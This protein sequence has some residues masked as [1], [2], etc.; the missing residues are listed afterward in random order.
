ML[1]SLSLVHQ[2]NEIRNA[3]GLISLASMMG[4]SNEKV[5][6]R[7]LWALCNFAMDGSTALKFFLILYRSGQS[8]HSSGLW[9]RG[10]YSKEAF[11]PQ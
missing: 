3:Q 11:K 5:Q 2:R 8:T 9:C 4:H 7:I 10:F 1:L 6:E